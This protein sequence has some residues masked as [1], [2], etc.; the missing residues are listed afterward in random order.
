MLSDSGGLQLVTQALAANSKNAKNYTIHPKSLINFYNN[1]VDAGMILDIPLAASDFEVTKRAALLQKANTDIMLDNAN[2]HVELINIFH[3]VTMKERE[4]YQSIVETDRIN[5]LAL[6]GLHFNNL[7]TA[8]S[9]LYRTTAN[10]RYKQYHVLGV[11]ALPYIVLIIKIA[12]QGD[13]PPHITS[14]STSHIQSAASRIYHHQFDINQISRRMSIGHTENTLLSTRRHLPCQCNVCRAIKHIDLFAFTEN[15]YVRELLSIHNAYEMARY[16][17]QLQ[18]ACR[19]LKPHEYNALVLRQ[20]KG[21]H[22]VQLLKQALHFVDYVGDH[23]LHAAEQKYKVFMDKR[24][25]VNLSNPK[26]LFGDDSNKSVSSKHKHVLTL[27]KL[28]EAQIGL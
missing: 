13:N 15:R 1:N 9:V 2:S 20:L 14:D 22:D 7:I 18:E 28:M 25:P 12:N 17:Q 11:F 27:I 23:G 6:G 16:T 21:S 8:M 10:R 24:R 3:G 26:T 5:R 19:S 4:M